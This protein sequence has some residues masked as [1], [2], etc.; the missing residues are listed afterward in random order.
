MGR[1]LALPVVTLALTA[2]SAAAQEGVLSRTGQ[3]LDNAG[4]GIRNPIDTGIRPR[5][6]DAE[7]RDV[8]NRVMR[9]IEWDKYI[10]QLPDTIRSQAG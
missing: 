7:E 2:S 3:A 1:L 5:P 8:L 9:R 4:R 6:M 10:A